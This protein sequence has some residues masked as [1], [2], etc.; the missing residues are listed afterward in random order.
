VAETEVLVV[1]SERYREFDVP[2]VRSLIRVFAPRRDEIVVDAAA[3]DLREAR[4]PRPHAATPRAVEAPA[5]DH[6]A[7]LP[8]VG[9]AVKTEPGDGAV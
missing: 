8:D 1:R 6:G 5:T 7:D 3:L 9:D 2:V 4:R